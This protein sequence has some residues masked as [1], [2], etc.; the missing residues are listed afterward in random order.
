M[1][2]RTAAFPALDLAYWHDDIG[3]HFMQAM[4][5]CDTFLLGRKTAADPVKPLSLWRKAIPLAI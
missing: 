1:R 4:E 2:I 5:H 3:A